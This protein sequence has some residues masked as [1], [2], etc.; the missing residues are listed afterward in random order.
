MENENCIPLA[1][2]GNDPYIFISYAHK[3]S[4][5]VLPLIAKMEKAGLRVW[6]D[7]GIEAGTEWPEYI[8]EHLIQ[9]D[10]VVV[11]L[12]NAS[13]ASLNCRNEINLAFA[14][15]K[16]LLAVYLEET[17]LRHGMRLQLSSV[18]SLFAYK[19]EED[20]ALVEQ[21]RTLRLL[22][23]AANS[24]LSAKD[25]PPTPNEPCLVTPASA[26]RKR[27]KTALLVALFSVLI[28]LFLSII[29]ILFEQEESPSAPNAP[30][31]QN[32][33]QNAAPPSTVESGILTV[34]LSGDNYPYEYVE[35]AEIKGIEVE[36]LVAIA[37]ELGLDIS[38]S[39]YD[40][41]DLLPLLEEGHA[42]CVIG[43]EET[44]ERNAHAT[45]SNVI[46][47]ENGREVILYLRKATPALTDAVNEA[48]EK[49]LSDGTVT[50]IIA[51]YEY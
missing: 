6:F 34:G 7:K 15:K 49:L 33:P 37:R 4:C 1:Y 21:F 23:P 10:S 16:K 12:S 29:P 26:T 48:I 25:E 42:D 50:R 28:A 19:K 14:E 13:V 44:E 2:E 40:F 41:E 31:M 18:Q 24:T 30:S 5:R 43:L 36:L 3:D 39:T 47:T 27:K 32:T 11:F 22:A 9:A 38:F 20:G 8:E 35:G 45:P 51:E 46:F 17:E